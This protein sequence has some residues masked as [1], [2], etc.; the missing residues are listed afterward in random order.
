MATNNETDFFL[1]KGE[2]P[3][4]R[5]RFVHWTV[6]DIR[7]EDANSRLRILLVEEENQRAD[8]N[9]PIGELIVHA[10]QLKRDLPAGSKVEITIRLDE[11]GVLTASADI[12]YLTYPEFGGH[13]S[14]G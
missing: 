6:S 1:T 8:R 5:A 11:S 9:R 2:L 7:R 14:M 4:A 13:G 3:P 12:E 10:S